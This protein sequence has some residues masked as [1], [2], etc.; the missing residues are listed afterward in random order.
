MVTDFDFEELLEK[1][2]NKSSRINE[3]EAALKI[4]NESMEELQECAAEL[5]DIERT[6]SENPK[7]AFVLASRIIEIQT[8][9]KAIS[10]EADKCLS[11]INNENSLDKVVKEEIVE[12]VEKTNET[13]QEEKKEVIKKA[14]NTVKKA[15]SKKTAISKMSRSELLEV[16]KEHN[17][18]CKGLSRLSKEDLAKF[19]KA[20]LKN[21]KKNA[22]PVN[23]V[24][25]E[26]VKVEEYNKHIFHAVPGPKVDFTKE[27]EPLFKN[28]DKYD[29]ELNK[30]R[31]EEIKAAKNPRELAGMGIQ[32]FEVKNNEVTKVEPK[33]HKVVAINKVPKETA[34][35]V[36][37]LLK[38]GKAKIAEFGKKTID[39]VKD[40]ATVVKTNLTETKDFA[41]EHIKTGA[42]AAKNNFDEFS[43]D[44][45][46]K[47]TTFKDNVAYE[48]KQTGEV[49]KDFSESVVMMAQDVPDDIKK[50]KESVANS[51][52]KPVNAV[53]SFAN[54]VSEKVTE[55]KATAAEKAESI[56]ENV[57]GTR[58]VYIDERAEQY[59][60][61]SNKPKF[62]D[63]LA[64]EIYKILAK[65][66]T[67]QEENHRHLA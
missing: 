28:I 8:R 43:Q 67:N 1:Y 5:R 53:K 44:M 51:M 63:E 12:K 7:K 16:C 64:A 55:F 35:K 45:K 20:S 36:F 37:G 19:V 17:F 49:F 31:A 39:F 10:E 29:D 47:A 6:I 42:E 52:A 27:T 30:M 9:M 22:A 13:I 11:V 62:D 15:K 65:S 3:V 25:N 60:D 34:T 33:K 41:V 40:K 58:P 66:N 38:S 2:N 48:A 61:Y 21:E 18:K 54:N 46:A 14:D 32:P 56:K 26:P 59:K 50:A 24:P 57:T 4:Y 23:P